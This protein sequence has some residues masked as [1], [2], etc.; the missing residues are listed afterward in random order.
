MGFPDANEM[1]F[2]GSEH[3]PALR[4]VEDVAPYKDAAKL[5]HAILPSPR[6]RQDNAPAH[7]PI[8]HYSFF[9]YSS[10]I[11]K[12]P[13]KADALFLTILWLICRRPDTRLIEASARCRNGLKGACLSVDIIH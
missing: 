3:T 10:F 6:G 1:S 4:C 7:P 5:R 13:A 9:H 11:K 12:A 8:I 2:G